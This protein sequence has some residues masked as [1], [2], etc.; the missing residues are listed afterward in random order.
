M[1][2]LVFIIPV[3]IGI[4]MVLIANAMEKGI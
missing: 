3:L 4:I 1:E 2:A